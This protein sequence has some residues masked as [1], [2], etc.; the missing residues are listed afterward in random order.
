[1]RA[2][3]EGREITMAMADMFNHELRE[4]ELDPAALQLA[5]SPP[6]VGV[7]GHRLVAGPERTARAGC[8]RTSSS[9]T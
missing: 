5:A 1:M 9:S 8:R 4:M 7:L 3:N 6:S 2:L